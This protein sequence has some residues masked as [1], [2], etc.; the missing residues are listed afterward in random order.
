MFNFA[1]EDFTRI[2]AQFSEKNR[3]AYIE[4]PIYSFYENEKIKF[5]V[6]FTPNKHSMNFDAFYRGSEP[7]TQMFMDVYLVDINGRKY[8][9]D[10]GRKVECQLSSQ[11]AE[12]IGNF[13][14][15][16]D[17]LEKKRDKLFNGD[18]LVV[19]LEVSAT[20]V[21]VSEHASSSEK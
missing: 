18:K 3:A 20:W 4:T 2:H 12:S 10:Y 13:I 6:R 14:Y 5:Q 11:N 9:Y 1:F 19:A 16:R 15:D 21:D 17:D 8:N 7:S